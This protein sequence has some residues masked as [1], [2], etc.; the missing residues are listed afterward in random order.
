MTAEQQVAFIMA[1]TASAMAETAGMQAE[2]QRRQLFGD[3][4]KYGEDD[5]QSVILRN[6]IGQNDVLA[7]FR[8]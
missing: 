1:A 5:F 3:V 6:G 8:G 7:F 4:P 2:N